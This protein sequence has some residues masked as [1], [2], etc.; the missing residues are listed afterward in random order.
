[1][2]T[3]KSTGNAK[4]I[5]TLVILFVVLAGIGVWIYTASPTPQMQEE[6][7]NWEPRS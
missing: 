4:L 2:P 6:T 7:L 5:A 3:P 1:M